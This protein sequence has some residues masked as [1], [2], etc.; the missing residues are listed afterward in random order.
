[1][2][3]TAKASRL[4]ER[5]HSFRAVIVPSTKSQIPTNLA[6]HRLEIQT[7]FCFEPQGVALPR[8]SGLARS[9]SA[10]G[11][12]HPPQQ[13]VRADALVHPDVAELAES[14]ALVE[15]DGRRAGVA[16]QDP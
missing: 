4:V 11:L 15:G 16:P 9:C 14:G 3:S 8:Q 1:M 2:T 12:D 6:S 10:H 5:H 7:A 13:H